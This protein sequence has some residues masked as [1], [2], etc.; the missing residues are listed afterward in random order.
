MMKLILCWY[1]VCILNTELSLPINK[2][3]SIRS[4]EDKLLREL[5]CAVIQFMHDR[6]FDEIKQKK[7]KKDF[8]GFVFGGSFY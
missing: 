7:R 3:S 5:D 4:V 1:E 6:M 2:R 8:R